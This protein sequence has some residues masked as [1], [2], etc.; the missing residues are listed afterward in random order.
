MLIAKDYREVL[1][2]WTHEIEL[3]LLKQSLFKVVVQAEFADKMSVRVVTS[4]GLP[5][6][7]SF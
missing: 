5:V 6:E 7:A 2:P 1:Q 3:S 4:M